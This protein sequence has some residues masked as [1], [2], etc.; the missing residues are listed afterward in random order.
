MNERVTYQLDGGIA[1]VTMDDG[2]V[3]VLSPG[4]LQELNAAFDQAEAD[5]A[6]VVLTGRD[7]RFSGG[8]E[9]PTLMAGGETAAQ[10]LTAGFQ[11]SLRLLTFPTPVVV[12]CTGHAIAMG[13]FLVISGDYRIAADGPFR[14]VANEVALGLTM[15]QTIVELCRLRLNSS[16]LTRFMALSETFSPEEAIAAGILDAIAAPDKLQSAAYEVAARLV[17]LNMAAF[18]ET[19]R[20]L[21]ADALPRITAAIASDDAAVR[22]LFESSDDFP[23]ARAS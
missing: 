11:L 20:R 18:A 14:L 22:S 1:T 17:T 15:P 12:A 10:M 21:Y 23:P 3:N 6:V 5:G 19:K 16:H 2:K 7:G 9:L 13:A 4:M 8:F